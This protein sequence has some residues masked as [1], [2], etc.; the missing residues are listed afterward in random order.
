MG[1]AAISNGS[2]A[3][4]PPNVTYGFIGIGVMGY[5]MAQN[6]RAKI[7]E[8]STLVLCELSDARREKFIA[9]TP[10]RI[11]VAHSPKEVAQ[12]AVCGA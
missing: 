4:G 8:S 5:G 3:D 7:P 12:K 11:E 10:G 2:G 9:E 6:L 1:D